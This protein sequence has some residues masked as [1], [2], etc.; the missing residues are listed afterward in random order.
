MSGAVTAQREKFVPASVA[1]LENAVERLQSRVEEHA[2][3][4]VPVIVL[5]IPP[6]TQPGQISK[7]PCSGVPIADRIARSVEKIELMADAIFELTQRLEV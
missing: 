3:A 2:K 1:S 7:S 5:P 4:L 6:P